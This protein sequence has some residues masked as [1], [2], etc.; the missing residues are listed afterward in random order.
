MYMHMLYTSTYMCVPVYI[1]IPVC[2]K[3]YT[4]IFVTTLIILTP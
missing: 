1:Y 4:E 2:V 3:S